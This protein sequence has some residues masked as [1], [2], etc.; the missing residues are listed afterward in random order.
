MNS[1]MK[2]APFKYGVQA[3]PASLV[4]LQ[5]KV[6]GGWADIIRRL[7][8]DLSALG[9]NREVLQVKEKFGGLR[10]YIHDPTDE[11]WNRICQANNESIRTCET[12]GAPA[13]EQHKRTWK[14]LCVH[15]AKIAGEEMAR[16]EQPV[17]VQGTT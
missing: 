11:M 12:C 3:T 5:N 17:D 13:R 8:D 15:C 2:S 6:G 7:V 10:F 1:V 9:W 16:K 14:T 4:D